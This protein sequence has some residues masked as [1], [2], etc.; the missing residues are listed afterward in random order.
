MATEKGVVIKLGIGTVWVKTMKSSACA[1]CASRDSCTE[2]GKGKDMEV[3]AVN[4]I[5]A[6]VGDEVLIQVNTASF[7]KATFL[8][9]VFPILCMIIGAVIGQN[10]GP[11]ILDMKGADA[12]LVLGIAFF[13][14]SVG[15]VKIY[16]NKLGNRSAYRPY[17]AKIIRHHG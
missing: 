11:S 8:L 9:Y 17:V 4:S 5:D 14:V 12:S 10:Y 1:S 16:G 13:I 2:G 3:E 15:V 7:M 6:Q